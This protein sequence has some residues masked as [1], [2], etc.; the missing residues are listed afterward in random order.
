MSKLDIIIPVYNEDEKII[1]L[2][3]NTKKKLNL[4]SVY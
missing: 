1:K 4:N 2:L 3:N